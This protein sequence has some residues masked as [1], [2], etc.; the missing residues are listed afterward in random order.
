MSDSSPGT[1]GSHRL[2]D[3]PAEHVVGRLREA[4]AEDPRVAEQHIDIAIT[5]H[6]VVLTGLV[7][8]DEIH[9]A[10][11]EL[12]SEMLPGYEVCN[13]TSVP[14]VHEPAAMEELA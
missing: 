2:G 9:G 10:A 8:S 7:S 14:P 1:S 13:H 4:L 3:E 11:G 5:G 6:R 12:A